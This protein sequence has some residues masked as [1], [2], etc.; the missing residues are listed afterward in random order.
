LAFQG[1]IS[2]LAGIP[3]LLCL[4]AGTAAA[5]TFP[6]LYTVSVEPNLAARDLR[7]DAVRRAMAV[8][9][10]RITGR[11]L[12]EAQ[13]EIRGLIESADSYV[14]SYSPAANEIRVGFSRSAVND[15]LTAR[16]LPIWVAER[17][18]TLVWLAL[19][20]GRGQRVEIMAVPAD[21]NRRDGTWA[22]APS[23][24]L[25]GDAAV[26]FDS[27][28]D[29]FA[30]AADERGLPIVLPLLDEED[31][32]QVRFADVWGG[33][34]QFVERA[35]GRYAVDAVLIGRIAATET[36]LEARWTLL[37]GERRQSKMTT[38]VR[39]GIDWLADEFAAQFTTVGGARLTW[40]TVRDVRNYPDYGR[41]RD[42]LQSVSIVDP[43][44][45]NVE[46]WIAGT[47]LVNLAARGDNDETLRQILTLDGVLT[48]VTD[49]ATG[50]PV[51]GEVPGRLQFV[52]G[53]LTAPDVARG[54]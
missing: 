40:I 14:T 50:I 48:A 46:S 41:V 21:S 15:A 32:Q 25:S 26:L 54:P 8:L 9:L 30:T 45:V 18:A 1:R 39:D 51:N 11:R 17:P 42:Y 53:W 19:D 43:A 27:I 20:L 2:W 37:R 6:E 52:P 3:L 4:L 22:G 10:T 23:Y 44:S 35:A 7:T 49:D 34:D 33:F 28:L 47:L 31:R 29:E 36:G 5:A 24:P 13:A 16:N 38:G 12:P